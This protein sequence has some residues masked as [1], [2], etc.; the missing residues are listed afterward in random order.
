ML[1]W[2]IKAPGEVLDYAIDWTD[3]LVPGDT[4]KTSTW[5]VPHG[6]TKVKDSVSGD[7][8]TIWLSG[9]KMNN[10][11]TIINRVET[12]VGRQPEQYVRLIIGAK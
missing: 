2:P 8:C 12:V 9:G 1:S 5:V 11:F 7:V 6:L 3:K 10:R 4:I